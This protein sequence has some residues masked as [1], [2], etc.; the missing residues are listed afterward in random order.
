MMY[1]SPIYNE[2]GNRRVMWQSQLVID[3]D[4]VTIDDSIS[5]HSRAVSCGWRTAV[6]ESFT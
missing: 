3:F 6:T 5:N 2:L 1:G 4:C